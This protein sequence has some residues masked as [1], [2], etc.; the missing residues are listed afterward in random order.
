[1]FFC[2]SM[3]TNLDPGRAD[4]T[5]KVWLG[6][7]NAWTWRVGKRGNPLSV[8][9]AVMLNCLHL[10]FLL[11]RSFWVTGA[12]R[13][14]LGIG[15]LWGRLWFL[16]PSG[17]FSMAPS[18]GQVVLFSR[19]W[20]RNRKSWAKDASLSRR[21]PKARIVESFMGALGVTKLALRYTGKVNVVW[22]SLQSQ[23]DAW[24]WCFWFGLFR[25]ARAVE[26]YTCQPLP[27]AIVKPQSRSTVK[28]TCSSKLGFAEVGSLV[29]NLMASIWLCTSY[30]LIPLRLT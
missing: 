11:P 13:D 9:P 4:W 22:G 15:H 14:S 21:A 10:G 20:G 30:W 7:V 17:I 3:D 8:S 24:L 25:N 5:K 6:K 26:L 23:I 12:N 29:P 18:K 2:F 19:I 27:F 16:G 28:S 1:M